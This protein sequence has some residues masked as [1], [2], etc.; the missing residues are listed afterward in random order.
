MAPT[1]DAGHTLDGEQDD[2]SMD[3][4]AAEEIDGHIIVEDEPQECQG[5]T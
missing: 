4:C 5:K 3:E 1:V 2:S